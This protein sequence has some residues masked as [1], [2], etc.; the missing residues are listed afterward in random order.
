MSKV[1]DLVRSLDRWGD[2]H[3]LSR[4]RST[5]VPLPVLLRRV[6]RPPLVWVAL[7]AAA[8]TVLI[9]AM[10]SGAVLIFLVPTAAVGLLLR[11]GQLERRDHPPASSRPPRVQ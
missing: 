1:S 5:V 3:G 7:L 10:T 11:A 8:L 2:R 9:A 4:D 6:G